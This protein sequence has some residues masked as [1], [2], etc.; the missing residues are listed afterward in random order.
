[1]TSTGRRVPGLFCL[2][3]WAVLTSHNVQSAS[4]SDQATAAP[5]N[6]TLQEITVTAQRREE[7]I[8]RVPIS[9][10]AFSQADLALSN[11]SSLGDAAGQAPGVNFRPVGYENWMTIR[12]IAQNA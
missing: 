12:G 1:M 8:Y 6:E 3:L 10:A 5:S 11:I 9:I 4:D 2:A 7:S